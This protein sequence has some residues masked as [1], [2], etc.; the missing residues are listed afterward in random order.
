MCRVS[1]GT[2][3]RKTAPATKRRA[4]SRCPLLGRRVLF[5]QSLRKVCTLLLSPCRLCLALREQSFLWRPDQLSQLSGPGFG[6]V[7]FCA[8]YLERLLV[9]QAAFTIWEGADLGPVRG[10]RLSLNKFQVST[11]LYNESMLRGKP[12]SSNLLLT[13]PKIFIPFL[14]RWQGRGKQE[15]DESGSVLGEDEVSNHLVLSLANTQ[16]SLERLR[17]SLVHNK[18]W[19][20]LT[21]LKNRRFLDAMSGEGTA[22]FSV[23]LESAR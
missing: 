13:S 20:E 14:P 16:V 12:L 3:E 23:L 22:C 8:F 6:S 15:T 10:L 5:L 21:L 7:E 17:G 4:E 18:K 1:H 9:E 19:R 11:E 2:D